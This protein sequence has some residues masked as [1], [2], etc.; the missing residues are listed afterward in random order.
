MKAS[1]SRT[2]YLNSVVTLITQVMQVFLGFVV[3]KV[4]ILQ[5]GVNY[6]GYNAVFSNVLQMLNLADLGI[7]V[8][9]TSFLYK[10]LAEHDQDRIAVLMQT[11]KKIY[12]VIGIIVLCIGLC[13][14]I[15]MHILIPDADCSNF[16]LRCLFYINLIGTVST[17]YLAYKR[18]LLIADQKS[19][20]TSAV[21][22]V[23]YI[24][25]SIIQIIVLFVIPNYAV[26]VVLT[27]FKNILSNIIISQKAKKMYGSFEVDNPELHKEYMPKIIQYIKDV[28]I[29]R[30]GA[31]VYYGT[32]NIIL[33]IFKGSLATGLLSNYTLIT[34]QVSTVVNLILASIQSTY[35]NYIS[36]NSDKQKQISM[37][38]MYIS[39]NYY[40]GNFC[41]LCV[42]FLS[43]P[44]VSLIFGFQYTLSDSTVFLLAVNLMLLIMLQLPSQVFT[45]FQLFHYDRWI[46]VVS[47]TLN[48]IVSVFL[49]KPWGIN[50]VLIGTFLTSLIYL[51]SRFYVITSK[52]FH[53]S[54]GQ[55]IVKFIKYW[56][57]SLF[58]GVIINASIYRLYGDGVLHFVI[59]MII[60]VSLSACIPGFFLMWTKDF[61]SVIEKMVPLKLQKFIKRKYIF[62]ISILIICVSLLSECI[63][64]SEKQGIPD[65]NKSL[66]R[67]VEYEKEDNRISH[68]PI[69]HFSLDDVFDIFYD[70]T[71]HENEYKSI[72]DNTTL[73][74]LKEIHDEYGVVISCYCYYEDN[75]FTLDSCTK[76]FIDEFSENAEWLRFGFHARNG[77]TIYDMEHGGVLLKIIL[78]QLER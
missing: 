32:D 59:C 62:I 77:N 21:D 55:Y 53:N 67:K 70:L 30:I 73:A 61:N 20:I 43:Q 2:V 44:F 16:Q 50:G 64:K 25:F 60:V 31:Y 4:F 38:D 48:I 3:R 42:L 14:S 33:S 45:I 36:V 47:A 34:N 68:E 27:V 18:T 37:T 28:F 13:I 71:V 57:I 46:I 78:L 72:F 56:I 29:S 6:L 24:I 39:S 35:G 58:S 8:A 19:Y 40:I 5:L 76:K 75:G 65:S 17:Y 7:G 22:S 54:F 41:M 66:P 52:V 9:I 15:F 1:R 63:F 69:F 51:F 23:V 10:P 12:Q 26:Y 74:W 49:V 11:Y